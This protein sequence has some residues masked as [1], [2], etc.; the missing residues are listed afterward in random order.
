MIFYDEYGYIDGPNHEEDRDLWT[1]S[2]WLR[3]RGAWNARPL[4]ERLPERPE[5]PAVYLRAFAE[6][7]K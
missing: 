6:E 4:P 2:A 3:E 7:E 1:I 5:V